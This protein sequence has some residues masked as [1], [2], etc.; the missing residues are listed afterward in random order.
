MLLPGN[1]LYLASLHYGG[2]AIT[3][4]NV[5]NITIVHFQF[6][7]LIENCIR[8]NSYMM[9]S[10]SDIFLFSKHIGLSNDADTVHI[11]RRVMLQMNYLFF[12]FKYS[13]DSD[14]QYIK[15]VSLLEAGKQAGT[16]SK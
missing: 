9:E 5:P 6:S 8:N 11:K 4:V 1:E 14:F 13:I 7:K 16:A 2:E 10:K 12:F 15:N 3:T